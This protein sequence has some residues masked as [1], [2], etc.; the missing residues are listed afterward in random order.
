MGQAFQ[1][2][3]VFIFSLFLINYNNKFLYKFSLAL[4]YKLE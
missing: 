1:K 2:E 4:F 3:D